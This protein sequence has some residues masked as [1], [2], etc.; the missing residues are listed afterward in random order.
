MSI[1]SFIPPP[2]T[3]YLIIFQFIKKFFPPVNGKTGKRA[4]SKKYKPYR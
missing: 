1:F 3:I 4:E 2:G